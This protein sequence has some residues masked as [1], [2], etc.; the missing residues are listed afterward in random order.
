MKQRTQKRL[1]RVFML[2]VAISL[3]AAMLTGLA[4]ASHPKDGNNPYQTCNYPGVTYLHGGFNTSESAGS[5]RLASSTCYKTLESYWYTKK[6]G[7]CAYS[8]P[9]DYPFGCRMVHTKCPTEYLGPC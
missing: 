7:Y 6:C 9:G 2:I 1:S 4:L 8:Y 5:H 3:V